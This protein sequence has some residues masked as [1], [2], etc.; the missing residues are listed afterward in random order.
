MCS[1]EKT[2]QPNSATFEG[3]NFNEVMM[4]GTVQK[5]ED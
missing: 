1:G 2:C 4:N 3:H 5:Y